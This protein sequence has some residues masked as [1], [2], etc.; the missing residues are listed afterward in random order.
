ML[1]LLGRNF[2]KKKVKGVLLEGESGSE[3]AKKLNNLSF[4][5]NI[6]NLL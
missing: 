4:Y 6:N 5:I 3:N 2:R 1:F